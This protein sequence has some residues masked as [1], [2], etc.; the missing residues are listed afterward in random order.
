VI[1]LENES[2]RLAFDESTGAVLQ[3]HNRR[4]GLDLVSGPPAPP[5]TVRYA[6]GSVVDSFTTCRCSASDGT[7]RCEWTTAG[8]DVIEATVSLAAAAAEARF[9]ASIVPGDGLRAAVLEYPVIGG[10]GELTGDDRLLHAYATGFLFADPL[11]LFEDEG[12]G[13]RRGVLHAPY[14]ECFSGAALQLM[15]YYAEGRGGFSF[16]TDDASGAQKWFDFYKDAGTLRA[17]IG[18]GSAD[19]D[20]PYRPEYDVLVGALVEG[21]WTEAAERY[22]AWAVEQRWCSRGRLDERPLA[23]R[24]LHEEVGLVTFGINASADRSRWLRALHGFAGTPVLHV[25]GP[26]WT[27]QPQDYRSN[28]PCGLDDW[29]PARFHEA[30]V[31]TIRAQGD[32]LVPFFF[33]LLVGADGSDSEE[34]AAALQQIPDPKLSFDG[35]P[36]PFV[37]PATPFLRRLHRERDRRLV[38]E[39]GVDGVYYDISINNVTARCDSVEHDHPPGGGAAL[40]AAYRALL[41]EPRIP[42]GTEM[43]NE[44]YVDRLDF[45]QARAEASP[46]SAFEADRFRDWVK[47]GRAEKVPLFA[48][49]Y[50]EYGPVRMDGWAKLSREQGDLF[51]WIGARVLAWGGLFELNY[52]FSPLEAHEGE[53]EALDEHYASLPDRRHEV[54][55]DKAAFVGELARARVGFAKRYLAYGTMLPPLAIESPAIDLDW[56]H[57]NC[58]EG[59]PAFDDR[60]TQTVDAVVHCAWRHDGTTGIVLVNVDTSAHSV[61][62]PVVPETAAEQVDGAGRRPLTA[63]A[64]AVEVRLEPRSVALVE[65]RAR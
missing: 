26:N 6:D 39:Y 42:R 20:R 38:E 53:L 57:Y 13:P 33:D 25:L 14:P 16:S 2:L 11:R 31:E 64:D 8:G 28:L 24:R 9:R 56:A 19:L 46:M 36:F 5:W 48:F 59:W 12:D 54:D 51:Y 15:A 55:P 1:V 4:S 43:V 7:L 41:D 29:F 17:A 45:Y 60:G 18:H 52:E 30:N 65:L 63:A 49:V 21:T 58:S 10:I 34:A 61:R 23:E 47:T 22:K 37:C 27:N 32:W 50:H 62:V 35:Y 3:I 44:L 40:V